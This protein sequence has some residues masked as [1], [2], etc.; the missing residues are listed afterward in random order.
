MFVNKYTL[1]I[2]NY[3]ASGDTTSGVTEQFIKVPLSAQHQLVDN[4]ELI[5]RVF[6]D[7]EVENSINK[8]LDY[9]RVRYMPLTK[10]DELASSITYDLSLLTPTGT[11]SN[12]YGDVGYQYDDVKFRKNSFTKSFLRLSLYD[13]DNPMVQ[14]LVGFT[15]IYSRLTTVDLLSGPTVTILGLPKPINQIGINFTVENPIVNKRGFSEGFHIYYYK[16]ALNIGETKY[17][18]IK[19]SFNNAKTG[20][21]INLMVKNS[22]QFVNDLVHELYTR[23]IIFRT[24]SGYYYKFDDTYQGNQNTPINTLNNITHIGN[25][26]NVKLHEVS[27]L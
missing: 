10:T 13:S 2:N 8:I 16:D 26:I 3:K 25:S 11:Y 6:V 12:F 23:I 5:Q 22:P 18:Y 21:S 17:L 9:D 20:K 24:T 15:T 7:T 19:A 27:A 1:N 4:D 14:N